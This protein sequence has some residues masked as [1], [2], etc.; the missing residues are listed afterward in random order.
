VLTMRL[1]LLTALGLGLVSACMPS[2]DSTER[3][4][5]ERTPPAAAATVDETV[6][7]D[8]IESYSNAYMKADLAALLASLHPDGPMYPKPAAINQLRSSAT[9]NA[10]QGEAVVKTIDVLEQNDS[11][12]RVR[13]TLFMRADIYRHGNFREETSHPTCE[14]RKHE[15]SWRLFNATTQ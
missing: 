15:G 8:V 7:K 3:P 4:N 5:V 13:V 9:G 11:R 10:L 2:G 12:A 14:L 6:Y 1:A